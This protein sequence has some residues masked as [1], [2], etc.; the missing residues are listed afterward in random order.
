MRCSS[1]KQITASVPGVVGTFNEQFEGQDT[2]GAVGDDDEILPANVFGQG[3]EQVSI[4]GDTEFMSAVGQLEAFPASDG[5]DLVGRS[6]P[7]ASGQFDD[8]QSTGW[9]VRPGPFVDDDD[10]GLFLTDSKEESDFVVVETEA[11]FL[12]RANKRCG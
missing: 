3:R 5:F 4:Q 6:V 7:C 2:Q 10:V 1:R 9:I 8:V 11:S 12:D